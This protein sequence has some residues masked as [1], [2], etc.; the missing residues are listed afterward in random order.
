[1]VLLCTVES[2]CILAEV[3][4]VVLTGD[5]ASGEGSHEEREAERE[6]DNAG[7]MAVLIAS[8]R[9]PFDVVLCSV[10]ATDELGSVVTESF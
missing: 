6:G 10:G 8:V 7:A 3:V 2:I 4:D 9:T 5:G 1:M